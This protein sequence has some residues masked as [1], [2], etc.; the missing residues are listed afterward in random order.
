MDWQEVTSA[1]RQ[2]ESSKLKFFGTLKSHE[3]LGSVMVAMANSQGGRVIIGIDIKNVHL[4]GSDI[5]TKWIESFQV[6]HLSSPLTITP[7]FINKAGKVI[8]ILD[9]AEGKNKPYYFDNMCFVM[10]DKKPKLSPLI[11]TNLQ[12]APKKTDNLVVEQNTEQ[13]QQPTSEA[14]PSHTIDTATAQNLASETNSEI[15]NALNERQKN[16][17][18][19]VKRDDFIKNKRYR[20]L[21]N[22]SHKTA[23]LELV[24]MVAK[25]LIKSDGF[26]R[27]TRYILKDAISEYPS[28]PAKANEEVVLET[29]VH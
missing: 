27:N 2:G 4:Y 7:Y 9:V 3:E 1:I 23:H 12:L 28:A 14:K 17:Y 6:Q 20:Q 26:G 25:D 18:E 5:D 8:V 29:T 13:I 19:I 15:L 10:E 21:F 16:A 22:V 24:D 11:K